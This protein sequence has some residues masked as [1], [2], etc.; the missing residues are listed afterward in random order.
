MEQRFEEAARKLGQAVTYPTI[1]NHDINCMDLSVFADFLAFLKESYPLVHQKMDPVLINGYS[2]VFC[3]KGTDADKL[4]VI[5]LAHYDVVPALEE[6]WPHGGPFSGAISD[7]RIWGR[8]SLDNK[9]SIIG[10]LETFEWLLEEGFVPRRDLWLA[11]GFDEEVNG[12]NG[13]Q[14]IV[15]WF[16]DKNIRFEFVLDEGG[17]VADGS[18]MGIGETI[19]VIGLAEKANASFEFTF[20]GEEGH[21]STPPA[22]TSLGRMAEFINKVERSPMPVR[23]TETVE[24]MLVSLAPYMPGIQGK[25]LKNPRLFFP[26][27]KKTLLKK[28]QTAAMLRTTVAFTMS[29]SGSAPN[30]LPKEARCT[31]NLRILQGDSVA[32]VLAHI[33]RV[34]GMD[35]E[36][37]PIAS[38]EPSRVAST[39]SKAYGHL[40]QTIEKFFPGAVT[41]PYLMAG[42][43][44]SRYYEDLADDVYRFQPLRLSELE[45][46]I[47]HGTGE[48]LS[49]DN[50]ERMIRFYREFILTLD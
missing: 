40:G 33:K 21:S 11:F 3:L 7:G 30:V 8:G 32:G 23:M 12:R 17:A 36:V 49:T 16:A 39:R 5:F 29:Q 38:E 20:T 25:V 26:L 9:S 47:I 45:M 4:P 14:E 46:G 42:G 48:Y 50:V 1:S 19:A 37:R 28:K 43:T 35:Y 10:L 24:A 34:S 27:L 15:K 6:G 44:D 22:H 31:A 13:A 41:M 2:P 18:M